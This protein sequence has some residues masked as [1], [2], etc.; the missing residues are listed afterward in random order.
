MLINGIS[1]KKRKTAT[2]SL[3]Q[4]TLMCGVSTFQGMYM[5]FASNPNGLIPFN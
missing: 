2:A 5:M 4:D 3:S 1:V